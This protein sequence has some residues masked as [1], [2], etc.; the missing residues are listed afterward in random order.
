MEL[1][2]LEWITGSRRALKNFPDE[3]RNIAG[4]QLLLVQLGESPDDWRPIREIGPGAI[5]IRIHKPHEHRVV[6]VA[7][8]PEAI[9]VLHAFEKK[10]QR[11]PKKDLNIA[12][13]AYAEIQ[14]IRREKTP[15]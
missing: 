6:Y 3:A 11:I 13:R 12:K 7:K 8:F 10:T 2:R 1:K 9:Y 4:N 14:K 5:E 15:N